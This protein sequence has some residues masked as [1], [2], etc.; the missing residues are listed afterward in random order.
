LVAKLELLTPQAIF[1]E[2]VVFFGG[3]KFGKPEATSSVN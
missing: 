2:D 1:S 3:G